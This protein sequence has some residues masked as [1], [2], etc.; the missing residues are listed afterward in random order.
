MTF[1]LRSLMRRPRRSLSTVT[2]VALAGAFYA[3]LVT[4]GGT[5]RDEIRGSAGLLGS[6]LTVQAA[7]AP[8]PVMSWITRDQLDL[9][10]RFPGVERALGAV[11]GT[12][13]MAG[14]RQLFVYGFGPGVPDMRGLTLVAG[15]F[16]E[17][18][19]DEITVGVAAA[20]WLQL[21]P[22]DRVEIRAQQFD[23]VGVYRTG[24]GLLDGGAALSLEIA[25]RLY[26]TGDRVNLVFLD[27]ADPARREAVEREIELRLPELEVS[28]VDVWVGSINFLDTVEAIAAALGIVALL[29]VALGVSNIMMMNVA[30]RASELAVL[31]AVGWSRSRIGGLVV[32]EAVMIGAMG[33]LLALGFAA[34]LLAL[35]PLEDAGG[36][37]QG[38]LDTATALRTVG[39]SVVAAAVGSLPALVFSLS[40]EPARVLRGE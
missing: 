8:V 36:L 4:V 16:F 12:T 40:V 34:L 13:R 10:G 19:A 11:I 27:L 35:L 2:G 23:V 38:A 30:E 31:R 20:E 37:L 7:R 26:R 15:R 22:G 33:G 17:P 3:V 6:D 25:Q 29:V 28:P 39:L 14:R 21:G 18:G 5:L 1:L 32:T 24:R 9:L